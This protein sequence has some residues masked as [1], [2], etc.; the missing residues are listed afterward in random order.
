MPFYAT[1]C[2]SKLRAFA[3]AHCLLGWLS[4]G[5]YAYRYTCH[6]AK[7]MHFAA[8]IFWQLPRRPLPAQ[9]LY[10]N[11][12]VLASISFQIFNTLNT[13]HLSLRSVKKTQIS[14]QPFCALSCFSSIYISK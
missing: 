7:H 2:I 8:S 1:A 9:S 3:A 6:L 4:H 10:H 11:F 12:K 13:W 14:S 5:Y